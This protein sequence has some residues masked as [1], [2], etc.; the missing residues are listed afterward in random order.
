MILTRK[1]TKAVHK[2]INGN[3]NENITLL[4]TAN[5]AG[6]MPPPMILFW[7]TIMP[8]AITRKIPDSWVVG[9]AQTGWMTSELFFYL[10]HEMPRP[11][12][13]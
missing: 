13:S 10:C 8:Q 5:A 7:Y 12:G 2:I 4:F 1:G 6:E 9:N 3:E 11:L